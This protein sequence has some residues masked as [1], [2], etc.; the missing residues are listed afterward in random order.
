VNFLFDHIAHVLLRPIRK[1]HN[2][3]YSYRL[4]KQPET[5]RQT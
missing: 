2:T 1:L 3:A 4:C 5:K